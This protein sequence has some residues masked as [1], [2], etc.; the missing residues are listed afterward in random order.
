MAFQGFT[1]G[2][3]C[4]RARA[5]L[6]V[7][8]TSRAPQP[9][10]P[11]PPIAHARG[12]ETPREPLHEEA[13]NV[14]LAR[15]F[16]EQ[17][18][19]ASERLSLE[20]IGSRALKL[21][22]LLGLAIAAFVLAVIFGPAHNDWPTPSWTNVQNALSL[23]PSGLPAPRDESGGLTFAK[24]L[25]AIVSLFVT[26]RVLYVVFADAWRERRAGRRTGHAVVCGLGAAGRRSTRSLIGERPVTCLE[27]DPLS[28]GVTE[29]REAGALVLR[30]D[31]TS[32]EALRVA[33]VR[34]AAVVVCAGPDDATNARI[35]V[36]AAG[37]AYERGAAHGALNVYV[38]IDD[39]N[40]ARVL[41]APLAGIGRVNFHPFSESE[42]WARA[43][44]DDPR[45]P[46]L[47][48]RRGNLEVVVVGDT[49]LGLAVVVEAARRWHRL[50]G[51]GG[52]ATLRISV[53][54]GAAAERCAALTERYPAI[55]RVC[56]LVPVVHPISAARSLPADLVRERGRLLDAVYLTLDDQSA[57]LALALE[58]EQLVGDRTPVLLPAE[59]AAEALGR[60]LRGVGR[61]CPVF[62]PT[63]AAAFDLLHD[64]LRERLAREVHG[65][66]LGT[67]RGAADFG[68][69]PADRAWDGLEPYW[70]ASN[71]AHVEGI[72]SQL[73]ATWYEI[74]P[75]YDWDEQPAVLPPDAVE[76]MAEL[77]HLRWMGELIAG[78][79]EWG[80]ERHDRKPRRHPLLMPWLDLDEPTRQIDRDLVIERPRLLAQAGFRLK[81]DPV[82]E[83]LAQ[84]HH[85]AYLREVASEPSRPL[86]VPWSE[87]TEAQR[88]HN[89]AAIDH[90]P[91]K[92]A[93]VGLQAV[94]SAL[95]S[96][97]R[98]LTNRDIDAM[99]EVEHE[100]WVSERLR[101]GWR[102]GSRDD[103][104]RTHPSLV[105]WA[106]LPEAERDVDRKL[107]RAVP[108]LLES[109][110]YSVV[111]PAPRVA[112]YV[113]AS[114]APWKR[115][116]AAEEAAA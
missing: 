91:V 102:R 81:R 35:A 58:A 95:V 38:A 106:E 12:P 111:D 100:R 4:G 52:G 112:Q 47:A 84:R 51:S 68:S 63:D 14:V 62:L 21:P 5:T 37:L 93:R 28:P 69:R 45:G 9:S 83:L 41:R 98:P 29:A 16:H 50:R 49:D 19:A 87:L 70:R 18:A 115:A 61:V 56:E 22:V 7:V 77:E 32:R 34:R 57:N 79:Y 55:G 24:Y 78:G 10:A 13:E 108:R 3:K 17:A 96:S 6:V 1:S 88:D 89:R 105:P 92:L 90:I 36:T 65:A 66:Y 48:A 2:C 114:G 59:A 40:L 31:A 94:P 107:V 25:V 46:F 26:A 60:L 85:E 97:A 39:P 27:I 42:V 113:A 74:E 53:V 71:F 101:S 20:R 110:G 75:L 76:A 43:L 99:A 80:A 67:R 82:R 116:R 104:Q 15:H 11:Q 44:L 33:A 8:V 72:V 103:D 54:G 86:A 109:V 64:D 23:F 73:R 30:R